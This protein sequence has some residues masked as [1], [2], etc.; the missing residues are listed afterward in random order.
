MKKKALI[1]ALL[2][3]A[4]FSLAGC[5]NKALDAANEAVSAYNAEA[6]AFNEAVDPYNNAVSEIMTRNQELQD[7]V[8]AA[9]AALDKGEV[10]FDEATVAAC[11]DA[12]IAA[13]DSKAVVPEELATYEE[14]TIDENAKKSD[15]E[16]LTTQANADIEAMK[17]FTVPELPKVPD[18]TKVIKDVT[19][20][21]V[22]YEDSVQG[23][24]QINAPSDDFV[25]ER[26]QKI[27]TITAIDA[28]TEEHDPNRKLNK[29]GGYIGC[30][31]FSDTQVDRSKLYIEN[32]KD[33]VID[34][35]CIGGGAIEIFK[36]VEE[37]QAR[38]TYLASF[39]GTAIT[40]GS[41]YVYGTI[42]IRTSDE[43]TGTKQLEL[44]DK[45]LRALIYVEH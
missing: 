14:L 39:D 20:A 29:Q 23:L 7:A 1:V 12:M 37:A 13:L 43:L 27:E 17:A 19:E 36:T 30:V 4:I 35:G 44:T 31:Y 24:K 42:I 21:K 33:N 40:S 8:D 22:A 28:V 18:Y 3:I 10:P 34:I 26:L 41:H 32:G 16:A 6:A 9:Q 25:M 38:D 11:K 45:I 15:L 2:I 5:G